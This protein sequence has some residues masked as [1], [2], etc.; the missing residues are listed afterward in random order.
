VYV[1]GWP[2]PAESETYYHDLHLSNGQGEY[3]INLFVRREVFNLWVKTVN[4][5]KGINWSQELVLARSTYKFYTRDHVYYHITNNGQIRVN[6]NALPILKE[7]RRDPYAF[8][9]GLGPGT[10]TV[11]GEHPDYTFTP[12]NGFATFQIKEWGPP[13]TRPPYR[14]KPA[15]TKPESMDWNLHKYCNPPA[16]SLDAQYKRGSVKVSYKVYVWDENSQKYGTNP[17]TYDKFIFQPGFAPNLYFW[18]SGY[19]PAGSNKVWSL[20]NMCSLTEHGNTINYY[21]YTETDH[22]VDKTLYCGGP[23]HSADW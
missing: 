19:L 5:W 17:R 3:V 6:E 16:L 8:L 1:S 13:G 11:T 22:E 20:W 9:T 23:S 10:Y 12:V 18:G 4:Y 21:V 7:P 14:F 15:A 2:Y